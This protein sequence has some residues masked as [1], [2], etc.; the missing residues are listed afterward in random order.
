MFKKPTDSVLKILTNILLII[1]LSYSLSACRWITGASTPFYSWTNF[2]V[3]EGT[4]VFQ[5]GFKDGCSSILYARGND[6]YR[7]RY[8]YRYDPTMIG[9]TEYRFGFQRGNS[10]CFQTILAVQTGPRGGGLGKFLF[11]YG[12][13]SWGFDASPGSINT[14]GLFGGNVS[15]PI[16]SDNSIN[17]FFDVL[18]KGT[19]AGGVGGVGYTTFGANPLWSGGSS[20]QFLGWY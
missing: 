17:G 16:S 4:P 18:Q 6:F 14:T 13:D 19:D 3:P 10:W 12:N 2:K 20:G 5:A 1:L 11:V 8:S 9:N 15:N 7:S